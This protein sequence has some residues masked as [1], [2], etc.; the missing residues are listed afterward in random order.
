MGRVRHFVGVES[1]EQ[2]AFI[3]ELQA[4]GLSSTINLPELVVVGDQSTGKSSVLQ[5]ITE[6]SFPVKAGTCT[7]FPTQISFRQT[8]VAKE[9]PIKATIV[10]GRQSEGDEALLARI[11]EF[12]IEK[13]ALGPED[14]SGIIE[15]A[16]ECIFGDHRGKTLSLSDATLRIE[17]SGPDEMHWTIVDLPG[18]IRKDD[19]KKGTKENSVSRIHGETEDEKRMNAAVAW[20]L[21]R[22]YLENERNIVLIVMD[23]VDVE[24]HRVWEVMEDLPGLERRCI[25]VLT[26]CDRKQEGSDNWM[27]QLLQNG[28]STVPHLDHGWFGL[29]NRV[30]VEAHITD[31]ERDERE[32]A[33]FAKKDWETVD[34]DRTGIQALM[35]YVDRERRAQIQA[36]IPQ[37]VAEIR[38]KLRECESD[39]RR[40]GDARDEPK[41][42]R[43]FVFQFCNDMQRMAEATLRGQYQDVPSQDSRIMLRYE[44]QRR[45]D[46]FYKEM[47]DVHNMPL[48]FSDF[49]KDLAVL[50]S[51]SSDPEVWEDIVRK[52]P[53]LYAE[54]Y[55]EAKI[56]EGRSLP[57]AVHP[58]VEEKI[59]RRQSTHWE[60]IARKFVDDVK[61][62]VQ[63]CHEVLFRIAIPNSKVRLEVSRLLGKTMDE[64]HKHIDTALGELLEDNRARPLVTRNPQLLLDTISADQSRGRILLGQK[65]KVASEDR[66]ANGTGDTQT[67]RPQFISTILSQV[68]FVRAR[69]QSYYMIALHRFI[70]NVAMQVIE[71][72]VLGPKC[73]VLAVSIET[74]AKLDDDELNA[75]AGEDESDAR[76]RARLERLRSR[77]TEALRRWERLRIL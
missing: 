18:L 27:I 35:Q 38:Q 3:D 69:L 4:L 60:G 70:D 50:N 62:L 64:W 13:K 5:A 66:R 24:R 9:F 46:Q 51:T 32:R 11:K 44:V 53:G 56:S 17:R 37:I 76:M 77:Y 74:F 26:K 42:Q 25:G 68:L 28:L 57:G 73:P 2:L 41:A 30:P 54:I 19:K 47:S 40:M 23:N 39:L 59:F 55:K 71:R 29:R 72:H 36:G 33:E 63:A 65:T 21:A 49:D 52:T 22:T 61:Q 1:S 20:E 31:A 16:T 15:K 75:I 58:D 8:S 45:L 6:V 12:A 7:R 14:M 43:Y 48:P 10:P 34:K 67:D